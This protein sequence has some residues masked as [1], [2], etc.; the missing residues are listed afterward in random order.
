MFCFP[1]IYESFINLG[2][3]YEVDVYIH[4]WK[5]FRALPLY[6]PKSFKIENHKDDD[7]FYLDL[8]EELSKTV[9]SSK[10]HEF[11]TLT[12]DLTYNSSPLKNSFLM[13]KSIFE[14]FD[15]IKEPY[16]I[17]IRSRMDIFFPTKFNNITY[18]NEI[19]NNNADLIAQPKYI[20]V[21]DEFTPSRGL[22]D[23]KLAILNHKSMEIYKNLFTEIPDIINETN[24]LNPEVWML[25]YITKHN[26]N[27][28]L[29]YDKMYICRK[30]HPTTNGFDFIN[31][32]DE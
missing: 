23:D 28:K 8:L 31:F 27:V 2:P 16:D 32:L 20:H 25:H 10:F 26:I 13:Y 15:L 3:Q 22:I 5:G 29:I 30:S 7:S 17:Y 4:S 1:Y 11:F 19:I 9:N 12:K 14:C 21:R 24:S 18:F 6:N